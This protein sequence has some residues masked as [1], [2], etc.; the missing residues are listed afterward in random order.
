MIKS[1]TDP[2]KTAWINHFPV[3]HHQDLVKWA[4]Q[5]KA[6]LGQDLFML[7]ELDFKCSGYFVEFGATDGVELSNTW[8]LEKMF[9]W[10]G[11]LA[12]PARCWLPQLKLNRHAAIDTH[13]IWM[14]SGSTLQFNE[15]PYAELSTIDAYSDTDYHSASRATGHLYEVETL[16]LSDLLAKH[17]APQQID[18]LSIDTEGSEFDILR[19]FDFERYNVKVITCEHNFT[20]NR[21]KIFNLLTMHGYIRKYE[22]L[23]SF[24]DWYVREV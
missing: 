17:N 24:D 2:D 18:Y 14:H 7:A 21:K 5:S 6:Q 8:L 16:S 10:N 1:K 9:D 3:K 20:S 15:T 22:D 11:I 12:E 4:D 13:C 23:S 19:N